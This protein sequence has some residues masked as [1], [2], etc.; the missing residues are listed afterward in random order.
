MRRSRVAAGVL[1]AVGLVW[2]VTPATA[3]PLSTC[4]LTI[5]STDA[6]GAALD[7][8]T[9]G[10]DDSSQADPFIVDWDGQV[11]WQGTTGGQEMK[12]NQYHIEVF[13]VPT[14]LRGGD[15]NEGDDRDGSGTVG[16]KA[17][18]PFRFT[19]LYFVSGAITGSG[20]SCEGSGWVK[21]AGDPVGTIPFLVGLGALVVGLV[22]LGLG[23]RRERRRSDPRRRSWPGS[24]R[25]VLLV[26]FSVL[27]L[28]S[29]TPT[30]GALGGGRGRGC[31]VAIVRGRRRRCHRPR[32]AAS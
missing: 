9:A 10:A 22:L 17:N 15:A 19:G 6:S 26:V 31:V 32:E 30:V 28:G 27:P 3:F 20:G 14:P 24:A 5:Q 21:L 11:A 25:S 4:A 1:A 23:L 16:V 8:A 12:A 2:A 18:A 7:G 29:L 13:G